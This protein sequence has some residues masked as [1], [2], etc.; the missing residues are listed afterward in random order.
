MPNLRSGLET[1]SVF[2]SLQLWD[3]FREKAGQEPRKPHLFHLRFHEILHLGHRPIRLFELPIFIAIGTIHRADG[4][5]GVRS[6]AAG[7]PFERHPA[8][9]TILLHSCVVFCLS[10]GVD[11]NEKADWRALTQA[12]ARRVNE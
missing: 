1:S 5:I 3:S 2:P 10:I 11:P 9:L 7:R 6:A 4:P 8:A 12:E